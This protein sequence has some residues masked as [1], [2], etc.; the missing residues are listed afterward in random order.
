MSIALAQA[1]YIFGLK[2]GVSG[3]I[4]YHDEQTIVYPAGSN[5]ILYNID[6]KAQKFIPGS[7]KSDGM[8]ALAVSPNRRYVAIAEK[9]EKPI[10]TV[11]DLHSL[12]KRKVKKLQ[13]LYFVVCNVVFLLYIQ[14]IFK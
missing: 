7:E 12:R 9:G 11:Y 14:L 3:N 2:P 8:T 5:C 6:Q 10:I 1:K 13:L 4:C